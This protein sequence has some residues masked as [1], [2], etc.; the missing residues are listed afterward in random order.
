MPNK[1]C[2][3]CVADLLILHLQVKLYRS[4]KEEGD[5]VQGEDGRDLVS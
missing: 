4:I 3:L 2:G 1:P 5:I